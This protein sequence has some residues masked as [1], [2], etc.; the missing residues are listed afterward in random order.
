MSK[1]KA[2]PKY[3]TIASIVNGECMDLI[4][5]DSELARALKRSDSSSTSE[6]NKSKFINALNRNPIVH[7][8]VK[9]YMVTAAIAG[10]N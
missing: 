3:N 4:L 1:E 8:G 5:T 2:S 7:N 9:Y 10:R 6:R